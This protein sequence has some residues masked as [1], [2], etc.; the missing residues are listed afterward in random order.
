MRI[1]IVDEA[2]GKI[3]FKFEIAREIRYNYSIRTIKGLERGFGR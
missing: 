2:K 3:T 1:T